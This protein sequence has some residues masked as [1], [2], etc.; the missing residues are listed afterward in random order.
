MI[1]IDGSLGEAG[2]Q[3]LRT[4]LSVCCVKRQKIRIF[5][6]RAGRDPPGLKAQ[7]LAVCNLLS[8]ISGAAMSGTEL[9]CQELSFDPGEI[10]GG[11]YSFDIGTAGSCT[12]L[13]QAALPVLAHAKGPCSL[14]VAGGTHVR[15]APTFEYFSEVFLPAARK[16]GLVC[17]A[18]MASAGFYPKGG[19]AILVRTQPS[20]LKGVHFE[21]QQQGTANYSI[22]SASLPS[23]VA[24]REEGLLRQELARHKPDGKSTQVQAACAGNAITIW[25]GFAGACAIGERGKSAEKVAAE[26]CGDFLRDAASGAPVDRHLADQILAYA[27]LS[28]GK[29]SYGTPEFTSH[30]ATNA[31]VLRKLTGRNIILGGQGKIRVE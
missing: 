16:F 15:G 7:H 18:E 30:L 29:S 3:V 20:N 26:A 11:D 4:A 17:T 1:E 28:D 21:P 2:G 13:L 8:E 12:L 24:K 22:I 5:D 9:G 23:H 27:A 14:R 6:I 25:S 10:A 19:G 31:S